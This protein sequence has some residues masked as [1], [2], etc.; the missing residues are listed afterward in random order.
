MLEAA[1]PTDESRAALQRLCSQYW[2]PVYAFVRRRGYGPEQAQDLTQEFFARFLAGDALQ[3]ADPQRGRFRSFLLG[4][5]KNLL[6]RDWRDSHRLKRGGGNEFI[7]WDS[8]NAEERTL[9]EPDDGSDPE[10]LFDRRWAQMIVA[11][12]VQRLEKEA[13]REGLLARFG[14]LKKFLQGDGQSGSYLTTAEK[15]GMSE[16]AIKSAIFRMRRRYGEILREE[17]R[18]TV[19]SPEEVEDEIRHLIKVLVSQ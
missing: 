10:L 9:V 18:Q 1:N 13:E 15:L 11:T 6:A 2:N 7:S 17:I 16:A 4:S 5:V 12:S 14:E 19:S 8:F 3:A